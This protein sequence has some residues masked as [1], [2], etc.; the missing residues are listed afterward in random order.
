[1]VKSYNGAMLEMYA[2]LETRCECY[3][4]LGWSVDSYIRNSEDHPDEEWT[5]V[6]V[7]LRVSKQKNSF[8]ALYQC[9]Y[10]EDA[11]TAKMR[12]FVEDYI[13]KHSDVIERRAQ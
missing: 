11:D 6:S 10:N 7:C 3:T 5:E 2:W 4:N 9:S 8:A 12:E 13:E 1:M